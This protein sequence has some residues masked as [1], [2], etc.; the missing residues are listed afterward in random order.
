[1]S[2]S[3]DD[4]ILQTLPSPLQSNKKRRI[5]NQRACDRCRQKKSQSFLS[6]PYSSPFNSFTHLSGWFLYS[7]QF[8]VCL[9]LLPSVSLL[10][11]LQ[12]MGLHQ[13]Q[14]AHIVYPRAVIVS[15]PSLQ[16]CASL[17]HPRPSSN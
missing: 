3:S 11:V 1:M 12:A 2:H 14:S 13:A 16:R 17:T 7:S 15:S 9:F 4:D 6:H 5:Q 8:V 10:D